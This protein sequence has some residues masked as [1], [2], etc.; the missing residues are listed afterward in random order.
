MREITADEILTRPSRERI[1]LF[2]NFG[3]RNLGSQTALHKLKVIKPNQVSRWKPAE[4]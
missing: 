4:T 2:G 1:T 3:A